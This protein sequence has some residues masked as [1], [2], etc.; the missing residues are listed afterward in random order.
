MRYECVK[1]VKHTIQRRMNCE[2]G[3]VVLASIQDHTE[4][5]RFAGFTIVLRTEDQGSRLRASGTILQQ[6]PVKERSMEGGVV[7]S[8][9]MSM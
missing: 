3:F 5:E 8:P 9:P 7:R 1:L 2:N 6:V 4:T